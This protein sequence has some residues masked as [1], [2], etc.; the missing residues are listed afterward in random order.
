MNN[1]KKRE[2]ESGKASPVALVS[3]P[4]FA[5]EDNSHVYKKADKMRTS[6]VAGEWRGMR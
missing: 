4:L 6:T 2:R 3:V 5:A 1:N